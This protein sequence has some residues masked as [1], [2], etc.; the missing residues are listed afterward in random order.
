MKKRHTE[1][2]INFAKYGQ[3]ALEAW[4]IYEQTGNTDQIKNVLCDRLDNMKPELVR[5]YYV[6]GLVFA[7]HK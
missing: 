3:D 4:H 6:C 5:C 1:T 7:D 2:Q